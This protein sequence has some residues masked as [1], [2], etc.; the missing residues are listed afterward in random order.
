MHLIQ[1]ATEADGPALAKVNVQSF[2]SRLLLGAV[3]PESD[4]NTIQEFKIHVGMRHLANP[5]MHVVKIHNDS[6]ELVTY[7]RWQFPASLG[8]SHVTLSDEAALILKNIDAYTPRPMNETVYKAFKQLL[9]EARERH[10]RPDD[11][12]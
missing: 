8:E 5:N 6:G 10:T 2:Q 7:S 9:A 3:W 4:Q 12:R 11:I 1:Y